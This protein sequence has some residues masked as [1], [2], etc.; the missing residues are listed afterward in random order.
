MKIGIRPHL[1]VNSDHD[2]FILELF[3]GKNRKSGDEIRK[4]FRFP[5]YLLLNDGLKNYLIVKLEKF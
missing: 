3:F 1:E 4:Q 2:N 5:D